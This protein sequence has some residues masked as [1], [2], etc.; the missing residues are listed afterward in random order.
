MGAGPDDPGK[1]GHALK[2]ETLAEKLHEVLGERLRSVIL[3]GSAAA[4]DHAGK[5]SD[6][7]ILV[8]TTRL[9]VPELTGLGRLAAQW[10]RAGNP[11]PLFFTLDRLRK[12]A[13]V[14]PIEL[15]DIRDSH[16]VLHGE[17]VVEAIEVYPENLRL[18]L[19]R[20]LKSVLIQLGEGFLLTEGKPKPVRQLM[21]DS[22]SSVL[23]LFRAALRLYQASVPPRKIDAMR[24][25]GTHIDFDQAVFTEIEAMK[26]GRMGETEAVRLFQRYLETVESV[27]DKVDSHI[28]QGSGEA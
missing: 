25:L 6:Y 11:P 24:E 22:L 5:E 18:I 4:G 3:Y 2:P 21:V 9:G 1:G 12:S 14:F 16:R 8:V 7:N 23:V 28:H 26:E 20:E 13:D 17:D 19:E 10:R 15:M 27:V